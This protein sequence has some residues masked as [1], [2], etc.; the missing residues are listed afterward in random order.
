MFRTITTTFCLAAAA[1]SF[2]AQDQADICK[3]AGK[4]IKRFAGDLI[5]FKLQALP[6]GDKE[7]YTVQVQ[8]GTV[9]VSGNS[10]VALCHGFY[11]ALKEQGL[12][13]NSWSG[14]RV[15]PGAWK[16]DFKTQGSTPFRYRYCFNVV[17]YGYTLPYWDWKR[18]EQEIDYMALHGINMPLALVA[19]EAITAR[20]FKRLG[21]TEEE[22]QGYL[23]G[24]AHLPWMRMGNISGVDGP[25]PQEWHKDQVALQHKI[26]KRMRD[27]DMTPVC[28]GFAGFVPEALKRVKPEVK[29]VKT[30]W[31]NGHYCNW[32]V[33]PD[34][35]IFKEIGT[36]FIQE[37]EKEFGKC[38]HYCIDSF[39]EMEV[40]FP[41]HGTPERYE[42]MAQY[43]DA[44]Y[45]S[46]RDANP[47]AVWFMQGWMFGFQRNIWDKKTLAALVS[48]VP[49][50]KMMLLDEAVDYTECRWKNGVNWEFYDGFMNKPWIYS[51]IPNMGGKCGLTGI[52]EFYANG[53]LKAL[54][55]PKKGRLV[56][57]G[58]APEGIENNQVLYELVAD[59]AWSEKQIDLQKWLNNYS[60]CRYGKAAAKDADIAKFWEL[61]CKSAYGSFTDHPRYN[62]QFSLSGAR[63]GSIN[64]N[65]EFYK[66]I[67]SFAAAADRYKDSPLYTVDLLEYAAAYLAG[68]VETLVIA[69]EK[70]IQEGDLDRSREIEKDVEKYMLAM[71]RLLESHPL[72]RLERWVDFA[73]KHGNG[74]RKLTDYYEMN[75]KRIVS[76]WGVRAGQPVDDYS[77][78][79]WS[80]LIRDYYLP[81]RQQNLK[82]RYNPADKVDVQKWEL[83]WVTKSKGVSPVETYKNPAK[84]AVRLIKETS[85]VTEA[86]LA[87]GAGKQV[88]A[89]SPDMVSTEWKEVS[90]PVSASDIR[91]S[92]G[93][94]FRFTSGNHKLEISE[95]RVEMDGEVTAR[96]KQDGT[97]GT[98]S[99][100]NSYRFTVPAGT[101]G[102]NGCYI[103]ARVR[104]VGGTQ[105]NGAV[106][107]I[108]AK[109]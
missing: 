55:S 90:W 86:A 54:E 48:K 67:E 49:D 44:V 76:I 46:I 25:M 10:S 72:W 33:T 73:R 4:V 36:M 27:L 7:R 61:M 63:K 91:E 66:A 13:I 74:D 23:V 99:S 75:A 108:P 30:S 94:R 15:E 9:V 3:P 60:V 12:G 77:A 14:N 97:A 57:H 42:L 24:P 50:D 34:Q 95:V 80:G 58:M 39:N 78:R 47:D 88:G 92:G 65:A 51:V 62:W 105:S 5:P 104:T 93:I 103:F 8:D 70:A 52:L 40:P 79:I 83:D 98:P 38:S 64:T 19:Q 109:K 56:G 68:K 22:I 53:H 20:V 84:S 87:P 28:P 100:N 41:P 85:A 26:L 35:P 107:L 82:G 45:S 6:K 59:A 31:C 81:R 32:M 16:A 102:N 11:A 21:L 1:L 89:W 96:V 29:L 18:W 71:D 2:G 43:G 37:W 106:E 69:S 101:S 17:T